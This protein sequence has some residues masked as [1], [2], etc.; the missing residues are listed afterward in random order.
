MWVTDG[1]LIH[2]YIV[3]LQG[4]ISMDYFE[5]SKTVIEDFIKSR[6]DWSHL[7]NLR[8][9][10]KVPE[11]DLLFRLPAWID[12]IDRILID[13]NSKINVTIVLSPLEKRNSLK[14]TLGKLWQFLFRKAEIKSD[15]TIIK[16]FQQ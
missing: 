3:E 13:Y 2:P 1:L 15:S 7:T 10:D 6:N 11:T 16:A 5:I 4:G 8:W 14:L 9:L 12:E